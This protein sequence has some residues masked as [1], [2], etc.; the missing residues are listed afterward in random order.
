GEQLE[1]RQRSFRRHEL[2][3]D[4]LPR[5]R[6]AIA[7]GIGVEDRSRTAARHRDGARRRGLHVVVGD[8]ECEREQQRERHEDQPQV[9]P[10]DAGN[11]EVRK[12][13][14]IDY[15][16]CRWRHG[17][18]LGDNGGS[19]MTGDSCLEVR[20]P[21]LARRNLLRRPGSFFAIVIACSLAAAAWAEDPL[22][23]L[24]MQRA[25]AS[26]FQWDVGDASHPV[27]GPIRFA[28]LT[29]P[30]ATPVGRNRVSSNIY[31]SCERN[32]RRIAIELANSKAPDDPGGFSPK[33]MPRLTC[34]GVD[35]AMPDRTT[36]ETLHASWSVNEVGDALARGL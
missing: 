5:E 20:S 31:V 9:A 29:K 36:G 19:P 4:P 21:E 13:H 23:R 2:H 32:A 33:T 25:A 3:L 14:G 1:V 30:V 27:L 11:V 10:R 6:R 34:N 17:P 15:P 28:V 22:A 35:A 7:L 26:P 8:P 18:G 16:A 24:G 12:G